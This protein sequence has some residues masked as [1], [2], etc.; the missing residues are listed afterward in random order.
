M[1]EF[2]FEDD[3]ESSDVEHHEHDH[4]HSEHHNPDHMEHS[5]H[6]GEHGKR[7]FGDKLDKGVTRLK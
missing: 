4:N 2:T 5:E 6:H 1:F 7:P 3:I